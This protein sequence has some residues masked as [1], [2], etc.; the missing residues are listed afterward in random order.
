MNAICLISVPD[1]LTKIMR[2]I[3]EKLLTDAV[4]TKHI[5]VMIEDWKKY[6]LIEAQCV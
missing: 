1:L 3:D 4:L 5:R 2:A 6:A